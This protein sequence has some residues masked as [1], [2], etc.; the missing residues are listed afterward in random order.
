MLYHPG[1]SS[2]PASWAT[3]NC[4]QPFCAAGAVQQAKLQR[5]PAATTNIKA[6]HDRTYQLSTLALHVMQHVIAGALGGTSTSF[7]RWLPGQWPLA[8]A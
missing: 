1:Q 2:L 4:Q 5:L 3:R 7:G 8:W 6:W